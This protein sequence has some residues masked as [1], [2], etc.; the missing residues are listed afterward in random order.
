MRLRLPQGMRIVCGPIA[1]NNP[2]LPPEQ[3]TNHAVLLKYYSL[4]LCHSCR[5]RGV[6][7]DPKYYRDTFIYLLLSHAEHVLPPIII[8]T[9]AWASCVVKVLRTAPSTCRA[10]V[11][12][13]MRQTLVSDWFH[14]TEYSKTHLRHRC[15]RHWGKQSISFEGGRQ[16]LCSVQ[17]ITACVATSL[18][19]LI[20]AFVG[21]TLSVLRGYEENA[22]DQWISHYFRRLPFLRISKDRAAFW[23]PV[24][25]R[26]ILLLSDYQLLF[27]VAILIAGYWKHC[28][29]SV[30]HFSLVV[31]LAFFSNTH[32]TSLSILTCYLQERPTLRNWR[33]CIMVLMLIMLLAALALASNP[34]WGASTSCPAQCLFDQTDRDLAVTYPYMFALILHYSTSI[35]RVFD[36]SRLDHYLLRIPRDRIRNIHQYSKRTGIAIA[37]SGIGEFRAVPASLL[38]L[39]LLLAVTLK[40]YLALAAILGSLTISLY[41]D[42]LWFTLGLISILSNRKIPGNNI[43]GDEN[44]LSFGQIVPM[45]LL[46]SIILTFKEVYTGRTIS[47][48]EYEQVANGCSAKDQMIGIEGHSLDTSHLRERISFRPENASNIISDPGRPVEDPE[49]GNSQTLVISSPN[50]KN[51][52]YL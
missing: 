12:V 4:S 48:S 29:I 2:D 32:M 14:S 8:H 49:R 19:N 20:I 10:K 25:E 11:V 30:Y 35:W 47:L 6:D 9:R 28:S 26:L 44:K 18:V 27:G 46:A 38:P 15:C 3:A 39:E 22:I 43:D 33:V 50:P 34:L 24:L 41:Y 1:G 36:T 40:I 45:L 13:D 52:D 23:R 51:E 17:I 7:H 21:H 31:D 16:N 37:G 5:E 42:I